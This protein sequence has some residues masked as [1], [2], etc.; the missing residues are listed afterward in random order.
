MQH[1]SQILITLFTLVNLRITTALRLTSHYKDN[2]DLN[3]TDYIKKLGEL[4]KQIG[5]YP[6]NKYPDPKTDPN[7]DVCT[8]TATQDCNMDFL[9]KNQSPG[10]RA[11][12]IIPGGL[13]P[14]SLL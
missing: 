7:H 13:H 12:I 6:I 5:Y 1:W 11:W 3:H 4:N 10:K 2:S 8:I 14:P 9:R